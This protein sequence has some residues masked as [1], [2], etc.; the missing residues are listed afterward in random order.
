MKYLVWLSTPMPVTDLMT[1]Q[2]IND[3]SRKVGAV[4]VSRWK[5]R[6]LA[7]QL[8]ATEQAV[9]TGVMMVDTRLR[10]RHVSLCERQRWLEST[11]APRD[12]MSPAFGAVSSGWWIVADLVS[13]LSRRHWCH[14]SRI[15]DLDFIT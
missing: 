10:W 14:F 13:D 1:D 12:E 5:G 15:I 3:R 11:G 7:Q 8:A 6:Q 9:K 4:K 2:A